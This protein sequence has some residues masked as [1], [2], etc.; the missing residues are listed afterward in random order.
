MFFQSY[1]TWLMGIL[2]TYIGT[3][4]GIVATT[5]SP[6]IVTL[7]TIYVMVW[8]YLLLTGHVKE[9]LFDGIKRILTLAVIFG[10]ALHLWLYNGLI[11]DTFFNSPFQFSA[12]L[13]GA[14][15]TVAGISSALSTV[16]SIWNNGMRI[17]NIFWNNAGILNGNFGDYHAA[18]LV[19]IVTGA[20][21]IYTLFLLVL[22]K[23]ALAVLLAI[24][25]FFIAMLLFDSTKRL[26]E[27]WVAQLANYGLIAI[28]TGAIAALMLGLVNNFATQ[29][30]GLGAALYIADVGEFLLSA[31]L[32]A[33][34]LLQVM[35]IADG[36]ATGIA[37][38][39][40]NVM[41][42]A[43][44]WGMGGA[45]IAARGMWDSFTQQGTTRWDP[46]SRKAGYYTGEGIRHTAQAAWRAM[47]RSNTVSQRGSSRRPD[48]P[49]DPRRPI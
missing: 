9:P 29:T 19:W 4:V 40:G 16:D 45:G 7:G 18:F 2:N 14:S 22:S 36:L 46:M 3:T 44:Q 1:W 27:S 6:M 37:L 21:C 41:G 20:L 34:I 10:V 24:G 15:G 43:I 11:I 39:T 5:L 42:R 12:I 48:N 32:V 38:S 13:V 17:A 25:P 33:L 28:L 30:V 8:G 23:I 47:G 35:S 26:F 49:S 31:V